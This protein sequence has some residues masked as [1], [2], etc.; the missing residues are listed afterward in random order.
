MT[1]L[2]NVEQQLAEALDEW[3][4]RGPGIVLAQKNPSLFVGILKLHGFE[5]IPSGELQ[6]VRYQQKALKAD[7]LQLLRIITAAQTRMLAL[8]QKAILKEEPE[9]PKAEVTESVKKTPARKS[10]QQ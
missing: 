6:S 7:I 10:A 4:L 8:D 2:T 3:A 5:I 9:T 1:E